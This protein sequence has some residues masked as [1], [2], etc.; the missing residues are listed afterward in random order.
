MRRLVMTACSDPLFPWADEHL[1]ALTSALAAAGYHLDTTAVTEA[2]ASQPTERWNPQLRADL[3]SAAYADADA[4]AI[5]DISGGNLANEILPYLDW[6]LIAANPKP[7]IGYSDLSCVLGAISARTGQSTVLWNLLAG[8][9]RGFEALDQAHRAALC[10][11]ERVITNSDITPD[12]IS[13]LPWTGGNLRCF[14]KLAGTPYWPDV[15][16]S[17]FLIESLGPSLRS[18]AGYLAQHSQL[19]TF[20]KARAIAVG[21]LTRVDEA[22]QRAVALDIVREYAAGLPVVEVPDVG[23]SPNSAAVTLSTGTISSP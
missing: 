11:P 13:R 23:H 20:R 19:G 15:T 14:L 6:T 9:H 10:R 1:P 18:I 21:Q 12:E 17:V 7:F 16:G 2:A 22:G 3:V 4:T 5:V 8:I